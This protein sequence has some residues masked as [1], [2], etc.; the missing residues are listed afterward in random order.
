MQIK[1]DEPFLV[2]LDELPRIIDLATHSDLNISWDMYNKYWE[3]EKD[4][5]NLKTES[6]RRWETMCILAFMLNVGKIH[7]I[8]SERARR[9]NK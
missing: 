7:G 4:N 5:A 6:G 1:E 9:K 8:R 2:S 3:H